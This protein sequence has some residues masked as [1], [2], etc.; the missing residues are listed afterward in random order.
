MIM[1][2][3]TTIYHQQG[4]PLSK[5]EQD[6]L[7]SLSSR[8]LSQEEASSGINLVELFLAG[9]EKM[10]ILS[11]IPF[12]VDS[13][14][15][16][17]KCWMGNVDSIFEEMNSGITSF[18]RAL[19]SSTADPAPDII[20]G[21]QT[22]AKFVAMLPSEFSNSSMC[23]G[24]QKNLEMMNNW[25]SQFPNATEMDKNLR[26]PENAIMVSMFLR[27]LQKHYNTSTNLYF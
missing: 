3:I 13:N 16:M 9:M 15:T 19:N 2:V 11:G 10:Y 23:A 24:L 18:V 25:I 7:P 14:S 8:T 12:S 20:Q 21:V 26:E 27:D 6:A 17:M 22:I 4:L 5:F 1:E